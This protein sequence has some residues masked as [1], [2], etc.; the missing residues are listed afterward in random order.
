MG[1]AA[2]VVPQVR[3]GADEVRQWSQRSHAAAR[4]R[5]RYGVVVDTMHL[6]QIGQRIASGAVNQPGLML[7]GHASDDCRGRRTSIWLAWIAD[8]EVPI[9][10]DHDNKSVVTVLPWTASQL[11]FDRRSRRFVH[12]AN[13]GTKAARTYWAEVR[14]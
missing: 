10:Y 6:L 2:R 5:E 3:Y 11:F 12:L 7:V 4:V 14:S 13:G 9:V 8:A 1:R